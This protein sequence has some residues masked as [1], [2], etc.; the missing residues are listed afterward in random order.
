LA[1]DVEDLPVLRSK[2]AHLMVAQV[3]DALRIADQSAWI[4]R[5][6]NLAVADAQDQRT[7]EARAGD[8]A[9]KARTDDRQAIGA[10]QMRQGLLHGLDQV[11]LEIGCNEMSDDLRIGL[12]AEEVATLLELALEHIVLLDDAVVDH[13]DR[14]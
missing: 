12:A 6:E 13:R 3:D 14:T 11:I 5:Q 2:D 1:I 8:Q 10:L 4:A 7:A 9:G